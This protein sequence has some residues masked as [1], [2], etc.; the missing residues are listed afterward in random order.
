MKLS[1]IKTDVAAKESGVWIEG[2]YGDLDLKIASSTN[3]KA[4]EYMR[5]LMKPYERNLKDR[6]NEWFMENIQ[7]PTYAKFVLIDWR[8]MQDDDGADVPYSEGKALELLNDPEM[9]EFRKL[10]Y[11]LADEF[12][13]FRKEAVDELAKK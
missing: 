1:S 3:R 5:K 7:N 4:V 2:C 8:N 9:E 13:L 12:E 6:S 10:V 11:S